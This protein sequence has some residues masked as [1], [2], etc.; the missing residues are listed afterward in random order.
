[1]PTNSILK[2]TKKNMKKKLSKKSEPNLQALKLLL[3]H[4]HLNN[5]STYKNTAKLA[6]SMSNKNLLDESKQKMNNI[7]QL[8]NKYAERHRDYNRY[9]NSA[10]N[11]NQ[12]HSN[13]VKYDKS[14]TNLQKEYLSQ[15]SNKKIV[16]TNTLAYKKFVQKK[17]NNFWSGKF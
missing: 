11:R 16:N 7:R 9:Y 4:G 8:E 17:I 10:F 14:R 1:M 5:I 15:K 2:P 6:I 3:R 13:S 12:I